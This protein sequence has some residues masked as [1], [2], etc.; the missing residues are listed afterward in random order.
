MTI[1]ESELI[2]NPDGSIYH[3]H[4]KPGD[5]AETIITVGD[6]DRVDAIT[7]HFD[8]ILLTKQNR[9][10][11][12]VTGEI[13]GKYI[14]VIATGIGTDNIDI[15]INEIDSLFNI[16]FE[17]RLIKERKTIL[18]FIRIGTS[19]AIRED[20]PID[21]IIASHYACGIDGLL[22]HY[23]SYPIRERLLEQKLF[24]DDNIP[25]A[26]AVAGDESL[27]LHYGS[28]SSP[29]ITITANGFYGPQSRS[30][31]L[32]A[33]YDLPNV[34]KDISY[35]DLHFTNLEMETAGIYG[36]AKLLGHRAISFNAILA[37]RVNGKFSNQPQKTIDDL[38]VRVLETI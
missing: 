6:P 37:N 24:I 5:L 28:I 9:E 2:I 16:D 22:H 34:L 38:I 23:D 12:T 20:V 19:G 30:L 4:L 8:K 32:A 31:R 33:K 27:L 29:G 13:G 11:K 17:T 3:L 14:S 18:T 25:D 35:Q 10:F 7:K 26:Y 36:M 15:V 21:S 1:P